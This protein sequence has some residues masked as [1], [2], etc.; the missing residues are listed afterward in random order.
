V[1]WARGTWRSHTWQAKQIVRWKFELQAI[2][3]LLKIVHL[4][5]DAIKLKWGVCQGLQKALRNNVQQIWS[6]WP[7]ASQTITKKKMD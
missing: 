5:A 7:H 1:R 3:G 6:C 4:A 2:A